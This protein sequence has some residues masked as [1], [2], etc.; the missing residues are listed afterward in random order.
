MKTIYY[1]D[2]DNSPIL[3]VGK[4]ILLRRTIPADANILY[5]NAFGDSEFMRLF[6]LNGDF[7]SLEQTQNYL[8][9]QWQHSPEQSG[10]LEILI[11]HKRKGPIGLLALADYSPVHCRAEYLIG[12]FANHRQAGYGIEATLLLLDLGFNQYHLNKI[13]AYSYQNNFQ[14]QRNLLS[15]GFNAEGIRSGHIYSKQDEN[16]IDLAAFGLLAKDFHQSKTLARLSQRMIGYDIT[17]T[18]LLPTKKPQKSKFNSVLATAMTLALGKSMP[19]YATDYPVTVGSDDGTGGT[20]NTLSWAILQANN[21]A[22]A[23]TITVQ[24]DV[25]VTG[26]M[27]TLI[28]SDVTLQNDGTARSI[29][30][31]DTYRPLFIKSGTVTIQNLSLINGKAKG[32]DSNLGGGGAGLGG[33]L[34]IY[35]GTVTVDM[36]IFSDNNATG[37]SGNVDAFSH[38]GGGMFGNAGGKGGGGLFAS[39]TNGNGAYGGNGNYGGSI[40]SFGGGGGDGG[41][42]GFGGG[43][44]DGGGYGGFGGGGGGYGGFGGSGGGFGGG[45]GGK[46]GG[47]YGGGDGGGEFGGGGGFG[48]G[49]AIFAMNGTTTLKDVSFSNNTVVIGTGL[50]D[51]TANARDLFICTSNLDVTAAACGAVVNQCG[52]TST[53]EIVGTFGSTCPDTPPTAS[54]VTFSGTLLEG[55]TL[56]G[57]YT[58][59][60]AE[61]DSQ[62]GTSFQWYHSDDASGT[63]KAAISGATSETYVLSNADIDK[64]ISFE[65]TPVNANSSGTAVESSINS[66][67]VIAANSAPA[68]NTTAGTSATEDTEYTY[69]PTATDADNDMLTWTISGEPTGM[70]INATTGAINWTPGEGVSTSGTVTITVSDGTLT[71]T[72][73]FTIAVTAVNDAPVN[74]VPNTQTIDEDTRLTFSTANSNLISISDIEAED[75]VGNSVTAALTATNGT[76]TLSSTTNLTFNIGDGTDDVNMEFSGTENDINTGLAGMIFTPTSNFNGS[77]S[78]QIVVND[79]TLTDDDTINITVTAISDTP[80]A[81][82][83]TVTLNEDATYTFAE[84]DFE[85]SDVDSGN[86]LNQIQIT[87]LPTV[88]TLQLDGANVTVDQEIV[89][90]DIS[91]LIFTPAANANGNSYASFQFKVHDGTSFSDADFTMTIDVTAVNDAPTNTVSDTQT[92]NEDTP[93]SFSTTNSNLISIS[94]IDIGSVTVTLTATNG[95]LTLSSTTNLTFNIGDGTDDVNMEFSGTENDINTGLAGMIFTPTSNFNGSASVQIVV[96]DGTLTD[97]DTINI[98]VNPVNDA[99]TTADKTVTLNEDATYPFK[100]ADFAFTD[101]DSGNSLNQIQITQ[102]PTVGTLQLDGANVTVDQEIVVADIS[103]L[104]FTPAANANGNSY[105]T[106]QFKVHDGTSFSD[107]AFTMTIDVTAVNDI[108]SF[109]KGDDQTVFVS[110]A[111]NITAWATNIDAGSSNESSQ[112]LSFTVT[113]DNESLFS[114]QPTIDASGNLTFTPSAVGSAVVTVILSDDIETSAAQT[115][116]IKVNPLPSSTPTQQTTPEPT[117]CTLSSNINCVIKNEGGTLEGEIKNE[118]TLTDVTLAKDTKI[119]GGQIE[120]KING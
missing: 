107:A 22:G 25:T 7:N 74:N 64:F 39:S 56:T 79:G 40:G 30:G 43:G 33:A 80:T 118:G 70:T 104:T 49:G 4:N 61:S 75:A 10:Y 65:V 72:E 117:G 3:K 38:G 16:F 113:N 93:L 35:N 48:G 114:V 53:T 13:D 94:D 101:I 102:L 6:R 58:Y 85:F 84:A 24:T 92:T 88:G 86:S 89:V 103:K 119:E 46:G 14:P 69:T 82:D 109:I 31:G 32:G 108:P 17:V 76:L 87:Q 60:D 44:G 116:N 105:A 106:F 34:F 54:S 45:G 120:G 81:A 112:T 47:G 51:G 37:G 18:N 67:A 19:A 57:S 100:E 95:T 110:A 11:I 20:A 91:K 59:A 5:E 73:T 78:V 23:D 28:N 83:K 29:S 9:K 42:G 111:Q 50:Q 66:T 21:N 36:V 2:I 27:K 41:D 55:E 26:V 1:D 99:P 96:N 68:I 98:T 15:L 77:A 115:F 52:S 62:N 97:D 12:L 90:A 71:D 63:N 8:E